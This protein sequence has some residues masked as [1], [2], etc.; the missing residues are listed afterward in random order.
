MRISFSQLHCGFGVDQFTVE[1]ACCVGVDQFT[2][3][4]RVTKF[5]RVDENDK[6]EA[7]T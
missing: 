5:A 4:L 1:F 7:E 6:A 3:A 2:I